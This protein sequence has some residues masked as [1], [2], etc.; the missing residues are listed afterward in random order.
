MP[1]QKL[2]AF[3][4][5]AGVASR[6]KSEEL[7]LA[8]RVEVN[9]K[10]EKNVATRVDPEKDEVRFQGKALSLQSEKIVL[11]MYKPAGVV[12]TVSDPDG[13]QTIMD[14]LPPEYRSLRLYP[15]GRLDEES[16]GLILLTNDGDLAYQLTHPKFEVPRTYEVTISGNLSPNEKLRLLTGVPLKDGRTKP[17]DL[18]LIGN[19]PGGEIWQIT[20]E[21]GRHHQIRRMMWAV[22]HEVRKLKRISHGE[23][24]LGNLKPGQVRKIDE[25]MG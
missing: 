22:N 5:H 2:A 25:T 19:V 23:Y 17:A 8:G 10:I 4:A 20:I 13:K 3:L 15:V 18:E 1:T 7:I 24:E 11:A 16:E 12:S 14:I 6:R 9:G 21:E